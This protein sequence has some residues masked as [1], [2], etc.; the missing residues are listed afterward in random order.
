MENKTEEKIII[1]FPEGIYGFEDVKDFILLQEDD[2]QFL[3]SLQAADSPYPTLIVVDPFLV[4]PGYDPKLQERELRL[5]GN[6]AEEDLCW[7][8]VAVI[9]KKL[10]D[11]VVSLKSPIVI[12]VKNRVGM[13]VILED[14]DYP[15]RYR[16]FAETG[17][18]A[19]C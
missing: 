7:L 1:H 6:P 16:L 5:L 13:Q 12:N 18:Q 8:T 2:A 4:M 3:W 11:S 10:E 15:L 17:G 19:E 9:R 14:G